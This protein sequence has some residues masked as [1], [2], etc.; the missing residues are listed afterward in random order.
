MASSKHRHLTTW[1]RPLPSQKAA[2]V[3]RQ[4]GLCADG[5]ILSQNIAGH[6]QKLEYFYSTF[7]S[8]TGDIGWEIERGVGSAVGW[9]AKMLLAK[10]TTPWMRR[11]CI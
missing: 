5:H 7:G 3:L 2:I 8:K 9:S 11:W 4:V 10:S 1:Q 6:R